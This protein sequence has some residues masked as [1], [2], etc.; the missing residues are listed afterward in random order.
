MDDFK[1]RL[2]ASAY[3]IDSAERR[4]SSR[5]VEMTKGTPYGE[6]RADKLRCHLIVFMMAMCV[7]SM[8]DSLAQNTRPNI[9]WIVSEDNN[10]A[11]IGC[12]G[13]KFATTPNIDKL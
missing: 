7:M 6:I 5:R 2:T 13:N 10:A 12:Y 1:Q 9:L 3:S 4:R 11:M 8:R